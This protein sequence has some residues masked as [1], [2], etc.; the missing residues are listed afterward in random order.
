MVLEVRGSHADIG[1]A[2]PPSTTELEQEEDIS[3][4]TS[5]IRCTQY[6]G[7]EG[8]DRYARVCRS[9]T[10]GTRPAIRPKGDGEQMSPLLWILIAVLV[11]AAIAGG[12]TISPFLL[13]LIVLAILI[14]VL[15]MRGDRTTRY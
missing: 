10:P 12:I 5:T 7:G 1:A 11:I 13:I 3:A 15:V 9:Q 6:P 4:S 8:G 2:L 14:Y